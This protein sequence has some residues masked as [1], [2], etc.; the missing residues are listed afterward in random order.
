[1]VLTKACDLHPN[2]ALANAYRSMYP[3]LYIAMRMKDDSMSPVIGEGDVIVA[4]RSKADK[5]YTIHIVRLKVDNE[6]LIC[7]VSEEKDSLLL[8]TDL[9]RNEGLLN[10]KAGGDSGFLFLYYAVREERLI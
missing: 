6:K 1:M 9:P 5:E 3:N 7:N 4:S 8:T 2:E 10:K